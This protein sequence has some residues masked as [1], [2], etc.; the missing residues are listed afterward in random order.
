MKFL[1]LNAKKGLRQ[2]VP[3]RWNSTYLMLESA[4]FYRRAFNH[5]EIS[6]SNYK[7]CPSQFEWDK[8]EKIS[9][10]L[11]VFYDITCVFSVIKYHTANLYF[12]SVFIAYMMLKEHMNSE[13][14]YLKN[15]AN[16]MMAKFEKYW[17]ELSIILAVAV[18]LVPRY[19][20]QFVNW[21]Y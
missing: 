9:S 15:M 5:L 4:I 18:I 16:L 10:F 11:S 19:K 1:S 13:D 17:S 6:D 12:L 21:A 3:T 20:L 8:V 7:S 14:V 2:D